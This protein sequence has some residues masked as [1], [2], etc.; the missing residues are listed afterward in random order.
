ME[1]KFDTE[2]FTVIEDNRLRLITP[3]RI[4]AVSNHAWTK[5]NLWLRSRVETLDGRTVSQGFGKFFN[6]GMGTES[7]KCDIVDIVN[8]IEKNDAIATVKYDGSLLI[9]SWYNDQ[10]IIRTRGSM[11]YKHLDNGYE[12]DTIFRKKYPKLFERRPNGNNY[13]TWSL[14]CE[15][16]T[17]NNCIVLKYPEP[18]LVLV[19]A[20]WHGG[21]GVNTYDGITKFPM[22]YAPMSRLKEI[23]EDLQLPLVES[24]KLDTAGWNRIQE[25]LS[26]D[27]AIEGY[28]IRING[29][30]TLIKVKNEPYLTKHRL[31]SNL[32]TEL[33]IDMWLQHGQP[34]YKT[35]TQL[36]IETYDEEICAW[37]IGAISSLFD[38]V[39][40]LYEIIRVIDTKVSEAHAISMS[41]KDF[42]ISMQ[43]QYGQT[44]KFSY[45]MKAWEGK[46][47]K[48]CIKGILLQTTR[49]HELGMFTKIA[50]ED[51]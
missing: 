32:T 4:T 25:N 1:N 8:A 14:L 49:Q 35:F 50:E 42:A 24:F 17:P 39:K 15:W 31:K 22:T 18:A 10:Q 19:G 46:Y 7:I 5:D 37:A 13:D 23:A 45:A 20:V 26:K 43:S 40:Q 11:T 16:I 41:R 9:F 27:N 6:L 28:V 47:D 29:E 48:N 51:I 2:N 12:I 33:L 44:R 38:G 36:F 21:T 34:D 3:T 30:Q